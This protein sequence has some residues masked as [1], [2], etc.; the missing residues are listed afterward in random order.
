MAVVFGA[1]GLGNAAPNL[2]NV[3]TAR[4]AAFS[5]W[6]ILDR[7]SSLYCLFQHLRASGVRQHS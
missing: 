1:F 6:E 5:L 7:V 4:G 3:A 2:K